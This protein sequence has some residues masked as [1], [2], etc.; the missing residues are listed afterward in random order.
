MLL[1]DVF[2]VYGSVILNPDD[3]NLISI[4]EEQTH[5]KSCWDKFIFLKKRKR[6]LSKQDKINHKKVNC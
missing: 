1:K 5:I 4:N 2:F 6:N 3:N